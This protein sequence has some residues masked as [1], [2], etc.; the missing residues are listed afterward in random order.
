MIDLLHLQKFGMDTT[1]WEAT[2]GAG[3]KL[4]LVSQ[5]L[6]DNGRRAMAHG[7]CPGVGVGGHATVVSTRPFVPA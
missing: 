3:T 6:H 1:T 2:V 4:G 5:K 7:V